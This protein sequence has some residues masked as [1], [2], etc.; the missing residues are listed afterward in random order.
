MTL[1]EFKARS[2]KSYAA[3]S[4]RL[5]NL[6]RRDRGAKL[7]AVDAALEAFHRATST[8]SSV[9]TVRSPT[10][11]LHRALTQYI[12]KKTAETLA[13]EATRRAAAVMLRDQV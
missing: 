7:T 11:N 10:S 8:S 1:S 13:H 2:P 9:Q 6:F 5:A 4:S 12:A 3:D